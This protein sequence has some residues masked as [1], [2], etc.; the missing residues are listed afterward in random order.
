[1]NVD[2]S[3]TSADIIRQKAKANE[4]VRHLILALRR[5]VMGPVNDYR[6]EMRL[7][8]SELYTKNFPYSSRWI[9][10]EHESG[11]HLFSSLFSQPVQIHYVYILQPDTH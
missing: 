1:M 11:N 8:A 4:H 7:T 10:P 3:P 5:H 6:V 9:S 2:K